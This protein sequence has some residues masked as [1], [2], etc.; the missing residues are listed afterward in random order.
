MEQKVIT[1]KQ[2]FETLKNKIGN[3]SLFNVDGEKVTPLNNRIRLI[4]MDSLNVSSK[5]SSRG[6]L[7]ITKKELIENIGSNFEE[8]LSKN[9]VFIYNPT[10]YRRQ[11]VEIKHST[12]NEIV[13]FSKQFGAETKICI[14]QDGMPPRG[15]FLTSTEEL[16]T[17][18]TMLYFREEGYIVQKPPGTYGKEG[19]NEHGVDDVVAWKSPV[20]DELRKFGFI[21]RGCHI[22]ELACLRWLGKVSNSRRD[23]DNYITK[24]ILLTEVKASM[25]EG[26]PNSSSTGI[27]QLSRAAKEKIAKKLFICF[28]VVNENVEGIFKEIKNKTKPA[29]PAVGAILFDNKGVYIQ[30]S[31]TFPDENMDSEIDKYERDLKRALLNNFYFDEILEMIKELGVDTKNKGVHEVLLNFCNKVEGIPTSYIL[32]KLNRL[33]K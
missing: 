29:E 20:I 17:L 27:N 4:L 19:K 9:F 31:E 10:Y 15:S 28:P 14:Q 25:K 22:S 33:L 12:P 5:F 13:A 18:I 24:E 16:G 8:H 32:E 6:L 21:D 23:F 26:I 1:F 2:A 3:N 7:E 30:E 11:G